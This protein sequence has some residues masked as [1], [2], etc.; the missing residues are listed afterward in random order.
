LL[1]QWAVWTQ[2]AVCHL[3]RAKQSSGSVP[4]EMLTLAQ[5]LTDANAAIFDPQHDFRGCIPGI[6]EILRRQGLLEGRWCLD[7]D[8]ELSSGQVQEI[9]R[10]LKAYPHLQDDEFVQE[11][12][13][14][15]LR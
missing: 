10:V 1:G 12:I 11:H 3:R 14:E 4:G 7:V 8:E 15:W 2:T 5:Q 6:H 9:D 13:D